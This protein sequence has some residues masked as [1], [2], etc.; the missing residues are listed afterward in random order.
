M[1]KKHQTLHNAVFNTFSWIIS[2]II[3]F[4]FL[5]YIV[6]KLGTEAYG[7]LVLVLAIIGYFALLDLNLGQALIKYVAE[8][9]A[10]N[11]LDMINETIGVTLLLFLV[12]GALGS[13]L[14]FA[15][16]EILITDFLKIQPAL[17]PMARFALRIGALGFFFTMLLS[18]VSAVPNGLD[19]YDISSQITIYM[20]L[21]TNLMTVLLLY[22]G[23]GLKEVVILNVVVSVMAVLGYIH[24]GKK[25]LPGIRFAPVLKVSTMKTVLSFG[26][27]SSLSR[28]ASIIQ[29]QADRILTGAILGASFVT[30]YFVPFSLVTR[31]MT[32]T[33]RIGGVVLPVVSGLQGEKDYDSV[34]ALYLK[35]SRLIAAIA[36]AICL[37]LLLFGNHFLRLWMG[38]EFARQTGMVFSLITVSLYIDAFTNVPAIVIHG[39]GR[40]KITGLFSVASAI[41]NLALI[42]P[43][44]KK[45]GIDGIAVAFLLAHGGVGPIF[46]Y[47]ANNKVLNFSMIRLLRR[48]YASPLLTAG[49]IGL[50]ALLLPH[51]KIH[52]I[53]LLMGVMMLTTI[54]YLVLSTFTGVFTKEE[55]SQCMDYLKYIFRKPFASA[56]KYLQAER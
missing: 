10:Q 43:L 19:R 53:F 44:A 32:V 12:L 20:S 9:R 47:Y 8:Y 38:E 15:V 41:V 23:F 4:I 13:I 29:F 35:A 51:E 49:I 33:A 2:I 7:V 1:E 28:L 17:Q 21:A 11:D 37:P 52:N 14:L 24:I 50:I 22:L 6:H 46:I 5:P 30:Y 45:M 39:L 31:A 27:F 36:T 16:S 18:V 48:V 54:S 26:F 55:R 25:L 34:I 56:R 3:N 40:P 42:Y